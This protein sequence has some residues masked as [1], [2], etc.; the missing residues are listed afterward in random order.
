[1]RPARFGTVLI[2]DS[3]A[4]LADRFQIWVIDRPSQEQVP[5]VVGV[6]M[7]IQAIL[8]RRLDILTRGTCVSSARVCIRRSE[9]RDDNCNDDSCDEEEHYPSKHNERVFESGASTYGFRLVA[10]SAVRSETHFRARGRD[11]KGLATRAQ[12]GSRRSVQRLSDARRGVQLEQTPWDQPSLSVQA[13]AVPPKP[14]SGE[15]GLPPRYLCALS[16]ASRFDGASRSN[17]PAGPIDNSRRSAS[18]TAVC[19]HP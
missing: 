13:E 17:T 7:Q 19:Q 16:F 5:F 18:A 4:A 3:D 9:K 8:D 14:R 10:V 2:P 11:Q 6:A 15:G 1:M 12:A